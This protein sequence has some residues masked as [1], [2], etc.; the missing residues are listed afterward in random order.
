MPNASHK[1]TNSFKALQIKKLLANRDIL[2]NNSKSNV[3]KPS[4]NKISKQAS[5]VFGN[6][7]RQL[8]MKLDNASYSSVSAS[9]SP[10]PSTPTK[11]GKMR[12]RSSSPVRPKAYTPSPRS[13]N[14]HR[15]ALDSPP[16]SP[17]RSS[18]SSITKRE[19]EGPVAHHPLVTPQE[20]ACRVIRV[21]RP[22]GGHRGRQE[23][24][25]SYVTLVVFDIKKH[26]QD[27]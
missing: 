5:N 21:I 2:S 18:N 3:R 10:S 13:P 17:R 11:S 20:C 19:V 16:Q 7:A 22:V 8:V 9:S 23:S 12:S 6:T 24:K 15:F 27:V 26:I 25:I 1:K 4:K 14:Y